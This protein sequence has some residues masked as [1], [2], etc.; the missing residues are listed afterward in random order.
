MSEIR[1]INKE[2][3]ENINA[4]VDNLKQ[5]INNPKYSIDSN[6]LVPVDIDGT[7]DVI[8][9]SQYDP[10]SMKLRDSAYASNRE[11]Y[12]GAA[13]MAQNVARQVANTL[14]LGGYIF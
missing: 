14:T 8:P 3:G 4:N 11:K 6:S 10:T 9:I 1:V 7:I 12:G 5:Y 13:G 2:S